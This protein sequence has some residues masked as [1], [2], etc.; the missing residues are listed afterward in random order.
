MTVG[1]L[2]EV[3]VETSEVA[4]IL[5]VLDAARELGCYALITLFEDQYQ[6]DVAAYSLRLWANA[7]QLPIVERIEDRVLVVEVARYRGAV[8]T[9]HLK[10]AP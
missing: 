2:N 7:N 1:A 8:I 9:L 6:P 4:K 10:D 3:G 5:A